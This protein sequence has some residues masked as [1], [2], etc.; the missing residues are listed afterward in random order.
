[1]FVVHWEARAHLI[2]E[3]VPE[4]AEPSEP[5]QVWVPIKQSP[6]SVQESAAHKNAPPALGAEDATGELEASESS[7]VDGAGDRREFV[8][9]ILGEK[10]SFT[11]GAAVGTDSSPGDSLGATEP[12]EGFI[13]EVVD[14]ADV[15][16]FWSNPDGAV[17]PVCSCK[18]DGLLEGADDESV[19]AAVPLCSCNV[20]GL[21][22]GA[23]VETVG[24][25]V[26]PC[27]CLVEG[28]LEG[29]DDVIADGGGDSSLGSDVT[30]A[31]VMTPEAVGADELT[32]GSKVT[33]SALL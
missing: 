18:A 17:V 15:S 12:V 4:Q 20:D 24:A 3:Q 11:I 25:E 21:L 2:A 23:D 5:S 14:G 16:V 9:D 13:E 1:M 28:L 7:T 6:S 29:A 32:V 26:P 30:G 19:G 8:E 22:V 10:V 27:S 33:K 31:L